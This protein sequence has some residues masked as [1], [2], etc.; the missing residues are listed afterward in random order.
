LKFATTLTAKIRCFKLHPKP[1]L[2]KN[3]RKRVNSFKITY[4]A[5]GGMQKKPQAP[6]LKSLKW[7]A[8]RPELLSVPIGLPIGYANK[9]PVTPPEQRTRTGAPF[10]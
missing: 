9:A 7:G 3:T 8:C 2:C 10:E 5:R 6:R 4:K 1:Y